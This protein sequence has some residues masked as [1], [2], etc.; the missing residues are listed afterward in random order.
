[1]KVCTPG[2]GERGKE[3]V[4]RALPPIDLAALQGGGGS[5][6]VGDDLPFDAVEIGA[7]AAGRPSAGSGRGRSRRTS[8]SD[9]AAG[10][11]IVGHE[12]ERAGADDLRNGLHRIGRGDPF[13]HDER[14]GRVR[15][16]QRVQHE[17]ERAGQADLEGAV[18]DRH[19]FGGDLGEQLPDRLAHRPTLYA[20]DTVRRANGRAVVEAQSFAQAEAPGAAVGET[21]CPSAICGRG[22]SRLSA[23]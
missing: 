17:R 22:S 1:M 9:P 23:E 2:R 11:E 10:N 19:V 15:L 3:V 18:I 4:Q 16:G 6:R 5:G 21:S 8:H 14:D 7:F 12:P 20:G 13:G